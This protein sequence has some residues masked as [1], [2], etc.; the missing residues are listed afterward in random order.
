MAST[1]AED[2]LPVCLSSTTAHG[3]SACCFFF[4][5]EWLRS[6]C[7]GRAEH[8]CLNSFNAEFR[9]YR[10]TQL[11]PIVIFCQRHDDAVSLWGRAIRWW[12]GVIGSVETY[13]HGHNQTSSLTA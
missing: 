3:V 7:S 13:L 2:L 1:T 11:S 5:A 8:G 10:D 6:R 9:H 12:R 4:N